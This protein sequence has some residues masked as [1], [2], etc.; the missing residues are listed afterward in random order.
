MK[1]GTLA[2]VAR[3]VTNRFAGPILQPRDVQAVPRTGAP[4]LFLPAQPLAPRSVALTYTVRTGRLGAAGSG[5]GT[6]Q[7]DEGENESGAVRIAVHGRHIGE[8]PPADTLRI[9][10]DNEECTPAAARIAQPALATVASLRDAA[11]RAKTSA[12]YPASLRGSPASVEGVVLRYVSY[13]AGARY[14]IVVEGPMR[15]RA[16]VINCVNV[17]I[18]RPDELA[19]L[20]LYAEAAADPNTRGPFVAFTPSAGL[21]LVPPEQTMRG[22]V[23]VNATVDPE[24]PEP[25]ADPFAR[26][27]ACPASSRPLADAVVAAV[28]AA[29]ASPAGGAAT[30]GDV[31][32]VTRHRSPPAD[33]LAIDLKGPPFALLQCVHVAGVSREHL[34]AAGIDD[35]R[36]NGAVGFSRRYGF[37]AVGAADAPRGA[38]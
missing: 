35:D 24:P 1:Y 9:D 13:D 14:A 17:G 22:A 32:T 6:V 34:R 5:A 3:N 10:P 30:P 16:S 23:T 15:M 27:E 7:P 28:Q 37:Y 36:R 19:S 2:L 26:R 12:G 4:A 18:A 25:P 11:E 31:V 20:H 29:L 8:T 38:R 33:W 21:Y